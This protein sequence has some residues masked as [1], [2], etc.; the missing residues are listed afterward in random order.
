MGHAAALLGTWERLSQMSHFLGSQ[1]LGSPFLKLFLVFWGSWPGQDGRG[2]F[3]ESYFAYVS[4]F[5]RKE[6]L[7]HLPK[8]IKHQPVK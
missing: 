6:Q 2:D 5:T 3:Q 1:S 4:V 7:T 8:P